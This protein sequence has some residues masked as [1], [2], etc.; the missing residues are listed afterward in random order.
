MVIAKK[1]ST[2]SSNAFRKLADALKSFSKDNITVSAVEYIAF[3]INE[4]IS[5]E[6]TF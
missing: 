2:E 1:T 4:D 3:E 6:K 5:F